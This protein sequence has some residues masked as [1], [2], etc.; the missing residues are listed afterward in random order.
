MENS[1]ET[2]IIRVKRKREAEPIDSLVVSAMVKRSAGAAEENSEEQEKGN[3]THVFKLM[4]TVGLKSSENQT[5]R[6]KRKIKKAF[7]RHH[8]KPETE[9][10]IEDR[11][12]QRQDEQRQKKKDDLEKRRKWNGIVNEW[13]DFSISDTLLDKSSKPKPKLT[14]V[15]S[16]R[17]RKNTDQV[18]SENEGSHEIDFVD[19]DVT[20]MLQGPPAS[21]N[22]SSLSSSS[23]PDEK[24]PS[25]VLNP[26]QRRIDEAIFHA[27]SS[28]DAS[29]VSQ[30]VRQHNLFDFARVIDGTTPL[31]AAAW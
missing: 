3:Q 16:K 10:T 28:G 27:F 14:P 7:N 11:R 5:A 23:S 1:N 17:T 8:K 9:S 13:E 12:S 4:D 18:S 25:K 6:I 24:S 30:L 31:M 26:M 21:P 29:N 22:K 2:T 20:N 19:I 15:F